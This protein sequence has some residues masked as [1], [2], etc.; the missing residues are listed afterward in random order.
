MEQKMDQNKTDQIL[1]LLAK[2]NAD[3]AKS[4]ANQHEMKVQIGGLA[5]KMDADRKADK[6]ES[7]ADKEEMMA[8]IRSCQEE[9][10]KALREACRE[11]TN[12]WL[13]KTKACREA[14]ETCEGNTEAFLEEKKSAPKETDRG[15]ARGSS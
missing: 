14:T 9:T 7:K 12:S 8:T 5:T 3:Q 4:V 11:A 2:M 13:G 10:I 1:E 15:G 6:E